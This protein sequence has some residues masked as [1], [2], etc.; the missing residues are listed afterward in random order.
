MSDTPRCDDRHGKRHLTDAEARTA[1]V[2]PHPAARRLVCEAAWADEYVDPD[3]L[4]RWA[5][6][7]R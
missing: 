6:E 5:A 2:Q 1:G 7:H 3:E 4:E